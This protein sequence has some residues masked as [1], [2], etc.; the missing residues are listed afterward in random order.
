M[1]TH[2]MLVRGLGV[3]AIALGGPVLVLGC[4][5]EGSA[6]SATRPALGAAQETEPRILA[7]EDEEAVFLELTTD[8]TH[9][10]WMSYD[11]RT[12]TGQI[13]SVRKAGG[14]RQ[15][16]LRFDWPARW[17]GRRALPDTPRCSMGRSQAGRGSARGHRSAAGPRPRRFRDRR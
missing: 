17:Q 1:I 16:L 11:D 10:Y 8:S 13:A 3:A 2:A 6:S 7:E 12:E 4:S 14:E 9:V 5:S 15:Q